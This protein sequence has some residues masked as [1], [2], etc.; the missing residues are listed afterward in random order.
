MV[1]LVFRI[2]ARQGRHSLQIPHVRRTHATTSDSAPNST[3]SSTDHNGPLNRSGDVQHSLETAT[4]HCQDLVRTSDYQGYLASLFFPQRVRPAVWALRALNVELASI[5]DTVTNETLGKMKFLYW[6]QAL[7]QITK[8]TQS[9]QHPIAVLLAAAISSLGLNPIWLNRL[10]AEREKNL[11]H[12]TYYSLDE[13]EQYAENTASALLYLQ[14]ECLGVK[15][16]KADHLASHLGKAVGIATFLRATPANA[17]KRLVYLP[18]DILAK[19]KVSQESLFRGGRIEGLDDAV[20]EIATRAHDHILTAQSH[21]ENAQLPYTT[22][23]LS[24]LP[25]IHYL[26]ALEK[27]NFDVFDPRLRHNNWRMPYY[28]WQANR[29]QQLFQN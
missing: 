26:R 13:V 21:I 20:F 25:S 16:V 12:A 17:K 15:D 18:Q 23:L 22:A 4:R 6:K 10:V 24:T 2:G 11:A 8:K 7:E 28:M 19:H 9:A 1:P 5:R 29:K 3:N 27:A 14:L